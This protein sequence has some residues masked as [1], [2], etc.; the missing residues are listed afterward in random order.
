MRKLHYLIALI[1]LILIFAVSNTNAV[2]EICSD[3]TATCCTSPPIV[4]G[5]GG[6]DPIG[7][8]PS[9]WIAGKCAVP[10]STPYPCATKFSCE[11]G[12]CTAAPGGT[13]TCKSNEIHIGGGV[14]ADWI[15]VMREKGSTLFK[16]WFGEILGRLVYLP[17]ADCLDGYVPG[18]NSTTKKWECI[19]GGKWKTSTVNSNDINY[20]VG[21]VGIGI[22]NPQQKLHVQGN[23]R[24]SSLANCNR[25]GADSSGRLFCN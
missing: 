4:A 7:G 25:I 12:T 5:G 3:G 23:L 6:C 21:N 16:L 15:K 24:I 17:D 8:Q 13:S 1:P 11:T 14:C 18:W 10:S 2:N 22:N 9:Y 20:T 19:Q